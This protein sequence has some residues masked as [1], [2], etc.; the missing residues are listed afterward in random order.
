MS[1][2][3]NARETDFPRMNEKKNLYIGE[4]IHKIFLEVGEEG[5]EATASTAVIMTKTSITP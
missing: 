4:V 1:S 5:I 2:A 3:F